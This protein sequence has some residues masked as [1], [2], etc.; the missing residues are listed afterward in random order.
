MLSTDVHCLK[1]VMLTILARL[2]FFFSSGR[3]HTR[4]WRDWSS[5]VC[6]SDL[7][8]C[9]RRQDAHGKAHCESPRFAAVCTV[10]HLSSL[11]LTGFGAK[12][13]L[14]STNCNA[15]FKV[16]C[17]STRSCPFVYRSH[18]LWVVPLGSKYCYAYG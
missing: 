9:H 11:S 13:T 16:F 14:A 5:D 1:R 10:T 6:S 8:L 3:R 17:P 12:L 15:K 18:I 7:G 2:N 4:Y